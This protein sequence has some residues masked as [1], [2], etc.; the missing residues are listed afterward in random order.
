MVIAVIRV[1]GSM[2]EESVGDGASYGCGMARMRYTWLR[3]LLLCLRLCVE[4]ERHTQKKRKISKKNLVC[5]CSTNYILTNM[6]EKNGS[7]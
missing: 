2:Q 5:Y 7:Y 6:L 1:F 4:S 3:L